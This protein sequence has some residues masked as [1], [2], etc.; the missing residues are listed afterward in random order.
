MSPLTT[1]LLAALLATV[2]CGPGHAASSTAPAPAAEPEPDADL[3]ESEPAP[4][5]EEARLMVGRDLYARGND[6]FVDQDYPA[7]IEAWE[8]VLLLMPEQEATLRAPLAHAHHEAYGID[9]DPDHLEIARELFTGQ[10]ES[11]SPEDPALE[12]LEAEID[13]IDA[14]LLALEEAKAKAQAEREEALRQEQALIHEQALARAEAMHQRNIQRVYYGVGGSLA[15][16]G[17]GTLAAMTAFLALGAKTEREGQATASMT[18][19]PETR[20]YDLLA[21]GAAHNR[22]AVVTGI[23]GGVLVLGGTSLVIVAASRR[24]RVIRPLEERL[25]VA[26]TL[27]GVRLRF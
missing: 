22:A 18:G 6:H 9:H 26:P 20:Y 16:A 1:L 8:Q 21:E 17:V 25:T 12:D 10:L 14:E 11:L 23:V 13:A 24:K 27:G 19:V 7:A 5:L 4:S 3:E 15:G 2:P